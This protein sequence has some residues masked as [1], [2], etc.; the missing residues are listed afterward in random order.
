MCSS[1]VFSGGNSKSRFEA[2]L[3][4]RRCP[5]ALA[6]ASIA[7]NLADFDCVGHFVQFGPSSL[8]CQCRSHPCRFSNTLVELQAF[9]SGLSSVGPPAIS[10]GSNGP[11]WGIVAYEARAGGA[12]SRRRRA[13]AAKAY[14]A[15]VTVADERPSGHSRAA[16][17][18]EEVHEARGAGKVTVAACVDA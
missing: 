16:T 12:T 1:T 15:V 8:I 18:P 2:S 10:P 5:Q 6:G 4:R 11:R 9:I 7:H 14:A 17:R 3:P 13:L